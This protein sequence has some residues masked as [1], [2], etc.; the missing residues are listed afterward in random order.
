[1]AKIHPVLFFRQVK[2]EVGKVVWPTRRETLMSSLMVIAFTFMAA[3]FF[4]VVDWFIALA[5]K[6]ILGL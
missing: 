6:H 4:F 3:V 5:M 1:M 2:Q